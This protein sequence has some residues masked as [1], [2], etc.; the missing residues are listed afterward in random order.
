MK[1]DLAGVEN[2]GWGSGDGSETGSVMKKGKKSIS[3]IKRR[4]T[5]TC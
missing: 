3:G 4:A 2:E 5:K 1:R